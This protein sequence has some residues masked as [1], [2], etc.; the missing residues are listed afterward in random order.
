MKR[1]AFQITPEAVSY[2]FIYYA[3]DRMDLGVNTSIPRDISRAVPIAGNF[4]GAPD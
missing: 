1:P 3:D 4:I 2:P